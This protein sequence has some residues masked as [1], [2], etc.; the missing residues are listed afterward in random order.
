M[1][2]EGKIRVFEGKFG[3][4]LFM[5]MRDLITSEIIVTSKLSTC[6][7]NLNLSK[8]NLNVKEL[9]GVWGL[10]KARSII[11]LAKI[12]RSL[13]SSIKGEYMHLRRRLLC[14]FILGGNKGSNKL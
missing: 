7:G 1:V 9:K 4:I 6:G 2:I 10:N 13:T 5:M 12:K 11:F 3:A 8:S 14:I